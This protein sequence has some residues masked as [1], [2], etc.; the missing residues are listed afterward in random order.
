MLPS[1]F[2]RGI[3]S[4]LKGNCKMNNGRLNHFIIL[5][6]TKPVLTPGPFIMASKIIHL[7]PLPSLRGFCRSGYWMYHR[8]DSRVPPPQPLVHD[9]Y[10]I[11]LF[12]KSLFPASSTQSFWGCLFWF[13]H[14]S[15]RY[16]KARPSSTHSFWGDVFWLTHVSSR[17]T[18]A[19][20]Y[21]CKYC[22]AVCKRGHYRCPLCSS[23]HSV[24]FFSFMSI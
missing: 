9:I 20:P 23:H 8:S 2:M 14:V 10:Q 16:T 6:S 22:L 24:F 17:Y 7:P 3:L 11:T 4:F 5:P 19:R 13:T 1:T 21:Y 15:S 12:T 18:K